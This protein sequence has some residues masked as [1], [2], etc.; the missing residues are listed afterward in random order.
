VKGR[1][2]LDTCAAIWIT[3]DARIS[4][5]AEASLDESLDEG[6]PVMLSPMTAWEIGMLVARGRYSISMT[7]Q[8]WF[9]QAV[10]SPNTELA[11]LTP[12]ILIQ[13]SFLPG[14]PPS[15]PFDRVFI[16]TARDR[17]YRIMTRD[18]KILNYA[19]QGHVQ[20]IAC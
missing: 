3:D 14:R 13:S 2:L 16:A 7:V 9:D 20:V 10:R 6:Q 8:S 18:H 19:D 11:D 15:D 4:D 17:G 1:I 5:E 12:S